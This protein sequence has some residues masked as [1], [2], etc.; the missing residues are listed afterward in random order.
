MTNLDSSVSFRVQQ[1]QYLGKVITLLLNVLVVHLQSTV[2][3]P[4]NHCS[5]LY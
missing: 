2:V 4:L 3:M 1:W 5:L